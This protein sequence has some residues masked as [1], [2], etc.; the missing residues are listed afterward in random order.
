[1]L[2]TESVHEARTLPEHCPLSGVEIMYTMFR[3]LAQSSGK[4]NEE[5]EIPV[6][7]NKD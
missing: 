2:A 7:S 6:A 1:M 5:N 4:D 3:R